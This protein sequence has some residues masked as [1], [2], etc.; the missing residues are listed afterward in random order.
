MS[1]GIEPMPGAPIIEMPNGHK[2]A[3]STWIVFPDLAFITVLK[4]GDPVLGTALWNAL[5][6]PF[7]TF[8]TVAPNPAYTDDRTLSKIIEAQGGPVPFMLNYMAYASKA[9]TK[10]CGFAPQ[11]LAEQSLTSFEDAVRVWKLNKYTVNP[12]LVI[13]VPN[14]PVV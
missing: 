11:W 1:F 2:Y 7:C 13:A 10:D 3:L 8:S 14:I 6:E 12:A 5:G 4:L 9:I